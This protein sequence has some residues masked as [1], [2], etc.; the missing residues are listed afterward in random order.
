M[1][2]KAPVM[3]VQ[4]AGTNKTIYQRAKVQDCTVCRLLSGT[5]TKVYT[6]SVIP[7][8]AHKVNKM[9]SLPSGTPTYPLPPVKAPTGSKKKSSK[10][11][12][13][14]GKK[15][16]LAT[17]YEC[18]QEHLQHFQLHFT[19]SQTP[20]L[21]LNQI[22]SYLSLLSLKHPP[23]SRKCFFLSS[24]FCLSAISPAETRLCSLLV[25]P[26]VINIIKVSPYDISLDHFHLSGFV[27]GVHTESDATLS[28]SDLLTPDT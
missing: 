3:L 13:L 8:C 19:Y 15:T 28:N 11:C 22:S 4:T 14:C 6:S 21:I 27:Q 24:S 25:L 2:G 16:G 26:Q 7:H 1:L 17:S 10:H 23:F 18:R 5:D 20:C 12:F 9:F